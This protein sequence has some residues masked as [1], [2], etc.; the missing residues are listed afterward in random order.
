MVVLSEGLKKK[1]S[2]EKEEKIT[3]NGN[4]RDTVCCV[5]SRFYLTAPLSQSTLSTY[6]IWAQSIPVHIRSLQLP[7]FLFVSCPIL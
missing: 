7:R 5:Y 3:A 1:E 2:Q 4:V 6:L